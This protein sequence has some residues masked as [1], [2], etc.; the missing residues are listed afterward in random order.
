M[1]EPDA[2]ELFYRGTILRYSVAHGGGLIRSVA[3]RELKF[4]LRFVR[5]HPVYRGRS[6]EITLVEGLEVGFDVGWTSRGLLVSRLFP[7]EA[8]TEAAQSPKAESP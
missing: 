1:P 3:G 4:D 6:P 5:L 2:A 7:P 8:G